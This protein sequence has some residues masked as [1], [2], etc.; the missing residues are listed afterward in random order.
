VSAK[1]LARIERGEVKRPHPAMLAKIARRLGVAPGEIESCDPSRSRSLLDFA[2][3]E[4]FGTAGISFVSVT[5]TFPPP[6]RW[7]GSRSTC[8]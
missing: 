1:S 8:L 7:G 5:Q 2:K 4:R 6:T 3:M